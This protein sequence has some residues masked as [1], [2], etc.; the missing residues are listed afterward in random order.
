MRD[1]RLY[2]RDIF[3][4]M[5][6]IQEF[7]EE[8]DFETFV[9]DDK[10]ASAVIRKLEIIGEATKNVPEEIRR[11]YPQVPWR[12]MAGMRDRLIHSYFEVDY[13]LVWET[14]KSQIPLLQPVIAQILRHLE[15]E[16]VEGQNRMT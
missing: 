10:T 2:L 8:M 1:H 12:Q 14:V 5:V 16:I 3:A 7:I 13:L 4:A 15:E 6:A 9:E 11:E